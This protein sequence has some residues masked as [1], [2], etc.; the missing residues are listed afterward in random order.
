MKYRIKDRLTAKDFP[1]C[2]DAAFNGQIRKVVEDA[3]ARFTVDENGNP[4]EDPESILTPG[5]YVRLGTEAARILG[6]V[7]DGGN[8]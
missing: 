1:G 2:M 7:T 6:F 4:V 5:E 3:V 8:D